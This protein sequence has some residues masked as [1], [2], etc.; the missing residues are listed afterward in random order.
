MTTWL[1]IR[2]RDQ[3]FVV[4]AYRLDR[5][6]NFELSSRDRFFPVVEAYRLDRYD[7]C[8]KSLRGASLSSCRSLSFG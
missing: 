6:D 7:N 5:Y 4:E 2:S 8:F 1:S 3:F